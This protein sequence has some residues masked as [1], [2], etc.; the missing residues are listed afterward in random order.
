MMPMTKIRARTRALPGL[1]ATGLLLSASLVLSGCVS[2]GS[3]PPPQ[4]LTLTADNMVA[5]GQN[6]RNEGLPS[7]EVMMPEVPRK[8]ATPRVPV[9]VDATS[10]AY[11]KKAQWTEAP[12][13]LFG[14]LLAQTIAADGTVFVIG[15]DQ[16]GLQ[17]DR[18]LSG[19]LLDFG[20][21]ARS[22]EAVVTYDAVL[23]DSKNDLAVRRRFTARVP[24]S[25]IRAKKIAEP[26]NRAANQVAQEVAAWVKGG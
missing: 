8:L 3:K 2:F 23:T 6:V 26:L 18:R 10:I 24:V 14:R 9:Q 5:A 25:D 15:E 20:V 13:D 12:R 11:V 7:L 17:P 4:L 16:Y 1:A 22:R 19:D 21:D